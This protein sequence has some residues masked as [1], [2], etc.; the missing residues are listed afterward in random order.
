[1]RKN[2]PSEGF[3]VAIA[4]ITLLFLWA[5]WLPMSQSK[6]LKK[7]LGYARSQKTAFQHLR[8]EAWRRKFFVCGDGS[9]GEILLNM[10]IWVTNFSH[11]TNILAADA[12]SS[13]VTN[14]PEDPRPEVREFYRVAKA[15]NFYRFEPEIVSFERGDTNHAF[16]VLYI[17]TPTYAAAFYDGKLCEVESRSESSFA[18]QNDPDL[19]KEWVRCVGTWNEKE[20]VTETLNTLRRLGDEA[21]LKEFLQGRYA[22]QTVDVRVTSPKGEQSTNHPFA[23]V[24]LIGSDGTVRVTAEYRMGT[25]GRPAGLVHWTAR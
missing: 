12:N 17:D 18:A 9:K 4:A 14:W 6:S 19:R 3:L 25:D 15:A 1:M 2:V 7:T 21:A 24:M 8:E 22:F 11:I 10:G 20:V 5:F 16:G 13:S 23:T